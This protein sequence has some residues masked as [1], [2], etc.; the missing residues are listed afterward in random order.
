MSIST[1]AILFFGYCWTEEGEPEVIKEICDNE[2]LDW[3]EWYCGK[4][5]GPKPPHRDFQNEDLA[6]WKAYWKAKGEFLEGRPTL[7]QHCHCNVPMYGFAAHGTVVT[8]YR[9]SAKSVDTFVVPLASIARLDECLK[10]IGVQIPEGGPK[11]WMVSYSD[12]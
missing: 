3:D 11:W 2:D 8:V 10:A 12:F 4:L 6:D 5:G 9:G 7:V 1:D